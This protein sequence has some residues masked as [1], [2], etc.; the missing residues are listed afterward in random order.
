FLQTAV[1]A[2]LPQQLHS[3]WIGFGVAN[4]DFLVLAQPAVFPLLSDRGFAIAFALTGYPDFP[5]PNVRFRDSVPLLFAGGQL[6]PQSANAGFN[7][8]IGG[9]PLRFLRGDLRADAEDLSI[10]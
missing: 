6:H 9:H 10:A 2:V 3:L 8:P 1:K 4:V 5:T 7:D